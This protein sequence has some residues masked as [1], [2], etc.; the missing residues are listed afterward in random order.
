VGHERERIAGLGA[1]R[2]TFTLERG[3]AELLD[4]ALGKAL[5]RAG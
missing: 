3:F 5:E 4:L 2:Q 1:V